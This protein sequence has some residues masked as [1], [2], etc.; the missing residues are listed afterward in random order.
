MSLASTLSLLG[1]VATSV[2][3]AASSTL[4]DFWAGHLTVA[5]VVAAVWA[6]VGHFLPSPLAAKSPGP[7]L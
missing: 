2:A 4:S 6:G 5:L 1:I 7:S 3:T